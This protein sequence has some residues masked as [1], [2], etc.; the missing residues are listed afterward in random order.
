MKYAVRHKPTHIILNSKW[1]TY[2]KD[3]KVMLDHMNKCPEHENEYEI[4]QMDHNI[5][6]SYKEDTNV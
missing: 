5:I 6:T 4:V 1:H 3:A 2:V